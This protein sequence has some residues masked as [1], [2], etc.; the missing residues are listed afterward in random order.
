MGASTGP[1]PRPGDADAP[2]RPAATEPGRGRPSP[3]VSP[4]GVS[5]E[6]RL[7]GATIGPYVIGRELGRGG[8][9]VVYAARAPDGRD[10]ALKLLHRVSDRSTMRFD[11][12]RRMLAEL[13]AAGGFVPL[14]DAGLAEA[15]P[16]IVMPLVTG[17][18]L[19]DR[20]FRGPLP[21]AEVVA[22]G[23]AV[24]AAL[25]RAH[26]QTIVH[27]DLK[28]DNVLFDEAGHPLIADLGLAKHLPG[29]DQHGSIGLSR[30]GELQGTFGY[31][32]PEQIKDARHAGPPADVY[33]LGA[34]LY[35]CLS[36]RLPFEAG[37]AVEAVVGTLSGR[38]R[39]VGKH[40][41]DAP[42]A[43]RDL[44]MRALTR[45]PA[46]RP[47]AAAIAE[48]IGRVADAPSRPRRSAGDRGG[49]SALAVGAAATV[50]FALVGGA[51]ALLFQVGI[52]GGGGS[53][54]ERRLPAPGPG[55]DPD[56]DP[57][58]DPTPP[59]PPPPEP[60]PR[61]PP[62]PT[63]RPVPYRVVTTDRL[64]LL[65]IRGHRS[66]RQR[67]MVTEVA[68]SPDGTRIAS[69][70][71]DPD[72]PV[73]IWDA[74]TGARIQLIDG[75]EGVVD[76]LA[77]SRD[78]ERVLIGAGLGE[79]RVVHGAGGLLLS[80]LQPHDLESKVEAVVVAPDDETLFT[81]A[82][83][84]TVRV[85]SVGGGTSRLLARY[86]EAPRDLAL[87]A[88]GSRLLVLVR[89]GTARVL[90]AADGREVARIEPSRRI[91]WAALSADGRRAFVTAEAGVAAVV[92]LDGEGAR[93][94]R[95][96]ERVGIGDVWGIAITP[97]GRRGILGSA[98][99]KLAVFDLDSGARLG[100]LGA[101]HESWA[102]A[103]EVS[104]D[105]RLLVTGGNDQ[106]VRIWDLETF[107]ERLLQRPDEG[108]VGRVN[109][110]VYEDEG[111]LLSV[112][113]DRTLRRFPR[114]GGRP[115]ILATAPVWLHD[116]ALIRAASGERAALAV[117][118]GGW[119]GHWTLEDG[120]AKDPQQLQLA[121]QRRA[122]SVDV[123]AAPTAVVTSDDDKMHAV[124]ILGGELRRGPVMDRAGIVE[125]VLL[126]DEGRRAATVGV[127]GSLTFDSPTGET[128]AR[129]FGVV[130][131]AIAAVPAGPLGPSGT[132]VLVGMADGGLVL[133]E[134]SESGATRDPPLLGHQARITALAVSADGRRAVSASMDGEVRLWD[135]AAR[136]E[137][138]VLD[139]GLERD[140][141][142]SVAITPDGERFAAG[143][144][145]GAVIEVERTD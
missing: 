135:L 55:P 98:D 46:D 88:D 26:A 53:G 93:I 60:R 96:I 79:V 17:G 80:V 87:S 51:G 42:R 83:D 107:E 129:T 89:D 122:T 123:G 2:T 56:P 22:V 91:E 65:S 109:G 137:L 118:S 50:A 94:S 62:P 77:W 111:S 44:V 21:I 145:T 136:R 95:R 70:G 61:P 41:P 86:E 45:E 75:H 78:G 128:R 52:G 16:Y 113:V 66:L 10:V 48:E 34:I 4:G 143:T 127:D 125:A 13:A 121:T 142:M 63:P 99:G 131:S 31:M 39:D 133:A 27:R 102:S 130:L 15:G 9:G 57:D 140:A 114:D 119:L 5:G 106:T 23:G 90:D 138:G 68:I 25:S 6:S 134:V 29:T 1:L 103:M 3:A 59:E 49:G 67:A 116:L 36:G 108:H 47:T 24:A 35:E 72:E 82:Q 38:I 126:G 84:G 112:G 20:L 73:A 132:H 11:R 115:A 120:A 28:P 32:A 43:L 85:S 74:T 54:H 105:G 92:E 104:A 139:L 97:D 141:A 40:R 100:M 124:A 30:T 8:M 144:T 64:R 19:R 33:S 12:E 71:L 37:T 76:A 14:I 18:S 69:S 101:G 7:A 117:G 58:V 110:L 81:S